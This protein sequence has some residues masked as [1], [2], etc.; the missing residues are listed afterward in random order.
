VKGTNAISISGK[1]VCDAKLW[2]NKIDEVELVVRKND[3]RAE[4][5]QGK[6]AVKGGSFVLIKPCQLSREKSFAQKRRKNID[7]LW[8]DKYRFVLRFSVFSSCFSCIV[9]FVFVQQT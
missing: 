3:L 4:S 5:E 1:L 2:K 9:L 6:S 7:M 8:V